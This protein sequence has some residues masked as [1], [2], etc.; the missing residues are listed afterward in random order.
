[1]D[2]FQCLCPFDTE[3]VLC[4]LHL[5]VKNAAFN[6]ESY[7][8][9]RLTDHSQIDIAFEAKTVTTDG[10]IFH[11]VADKIFMSLYIRD[12]FLEFKF[13]CGYQTMLLKELRTSVNKGYMMHIEAKYK[14]E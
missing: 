14:N 4:E 1:M 7:L 8:V 2:S 12:G 5:G 3:G 13:S 6:G 10:V 11:L 9:H